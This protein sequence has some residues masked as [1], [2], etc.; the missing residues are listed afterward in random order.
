MPTVHL[1]MPVNH[2]NNDDGGY[3]VT[4]I[5]AGFLQ[6]LLGRRQLTEWKGASAIKFGL[7]F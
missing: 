5:F 6:E 2:V 3:A 1:G 7:S 4:G